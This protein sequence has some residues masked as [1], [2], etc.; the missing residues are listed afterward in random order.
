MLL[1]CINLYS[2][3]KTGVGDGYACGTM[4][5]IVELSVTDTKVNDI[6]ISPQPAVNEAFITLDI[7]ANNAIIDLYDIMGCLVSTY[8]YNA[9]NEGINRLR[10]DLSK[11]QSGIYNAII[12]SADEIYQTKILKVD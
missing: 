1:S 8:N 5:S 6:I 10:L 12:K 2:Q 3:F 4:T 9:L 11:I 7:S